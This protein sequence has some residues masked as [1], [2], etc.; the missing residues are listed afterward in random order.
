[1]CC[2]LFFF[3]CE[4][5]CLG[6]CFFFFQAEDGIR[7]ADVTGVQTCALPICR[8]LAYSFPPCSPDPSHP[9][10]LA[11]PRFVRAPPALP[12]TTRIRLPP[13]S[14]PCCDRTAAKV[15]HLHSNKQ[16]L[17]A[18]RDVPPAGT[19]L[20]RE[21]DVVP[22]GEPGQPGPQVRPVG[23]GDLAPADLPG[24]GVQIVEGDLLP[25]NV[26]PAYDGHRD[27]LKLPRAHQ[28]PARGLLTRLIV[29]R[30]S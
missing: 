22:A 10:V 11:R 23:R 8:F 27:L 30:L 24:G 7:D 5:K 2:F 13:A 18:Q 15:S 29:T 1:M 12:G 16:R 4:V 17:T 19:A 21:R 28:R 25:V 26:E 9:A 3:F 14:P 6:G 20:Q